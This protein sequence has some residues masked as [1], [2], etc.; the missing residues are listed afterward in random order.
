MPH[1]LRHKLCMLVSE[2]SNFTDPKLNDFR[3]KV[4][5]SSCILDVTAKLTR[6]T[7]GTQIC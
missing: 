2:L 5:A 3:K 1:K 4:A 7:G 6:D